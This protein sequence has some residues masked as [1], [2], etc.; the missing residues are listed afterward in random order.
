MLKHEYPDYASH[1]S[2]HTK[3]SRIFQVKTDYEAGNCG[4]EPAIKVLDGACDWLRSHIS[5]IDKRLGSF[6]KSV[7]KS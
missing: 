3:S 1:K 2:A 7:E 5:Q 6:L 4:S